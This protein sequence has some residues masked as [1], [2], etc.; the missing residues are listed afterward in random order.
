MKALLLTSCILMV[1]AAQAQNDRG[2]I[3]N[4]P[5]QGGD[6]VVVQEFDQDTLPSTTRMWR[7]PYFEARI[8]MGI[9]GFNGIQTGGFQ[10]EIEV[11]SQLSELIGVQAS[12][13]GTISQG[14]NHPAPESIQQN[15]DVFNSWEANAMAVFT[16][17]E[18]DKRKV[19]PVSWKYYTPLRVRYEIHSQT[20]TQVKYRHQARIGWNQRGG[21]L[22]GYTSSFAD[23][24][25]RFVAWNDFNYG[26]LSLGYAW[27]MDRIL[28]VLPV[29][30]YGGK[31]LNRSRTI[32]IDLLANLFHTADGQIMQGDGLGNYTYVE[33][34]AKSN[35][36][37]A[38]LGVRAGYRGTYLFNGEGFGIY[39]KY[40]MGWQPAFNDN[41]LGLNN[42]TAGSQFYFSA[43]VGLQF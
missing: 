25:D 31:N 12:F 36:S 24:S 29:K 40:E 38:A 30:N 35:L 41:S 37:F 9:G 26:N 6:V 13:I 3:I 27:R 22:A 18:T 8:G 5:S 11:Y 16:L 39:H 19:H 2:I 23:G 33:D 1:S 7:D 21:H 4:D 15:T 28:E 10:P 32:Y 43:A 14:D 20:Q 42:I 17:G 34:V